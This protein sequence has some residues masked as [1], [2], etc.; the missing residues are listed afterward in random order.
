MENNMP[1]RNNPRPVPAVTVLIAALA[2]GICLIIAAV[3]VSGSV[4]KL[5]A[6]VEAQ[7]FTSSLNSPSTITVMNTAPKN[8]YTEKE[9]AAYLN[10]SEDEIK[11]AI[12]KG[13]IDEYIKTS[14]GYTISQSELDDYF[15]QKAYDTMRSNNESTSSE[16]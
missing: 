6:A 12:T 9:A 15:E 8:Y 16:S 14:T 10:V 11:A 4:K 3:I 1:R 13:E 5:T 2:L 7:T